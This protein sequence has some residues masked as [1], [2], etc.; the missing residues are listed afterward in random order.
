MIKDL[1]ISINYWQDFLTTLASTYGI[2]F[3]LMD[4][5]GNI[6]SNTVNERTLCSY[7][8]R[9]ENSSLKCKE[10]CRDIPLQAVSEENIK[11]YN[12]Y[13]GI[14]CFAIPI[15]IS[16]SEKGVILGGKVLTDIPYTEAYSEKCRQLGININEV[17]NSLHELK[18]MKEKCIGAYIELIDNFAKKAALMEVDIS[19]YAEK[20]KQFKRI[21]SGI[22][23]LHEN[24]A[25]DREFLFSIIR[26]A[27]EAF[28]VK[29]VSLI[30]KKGNNFESVA[31]IRDYIDTG[32][33]SGITLKSNS[34]LI[35]KIIE[36]GK[37]PLILDDSKLISELGIKWGAETISI[38]PVFKSHKLWGILLFFNF[39]DDSDTRENLRFFAENIEKTIESIE[40][41]NQLKLINHNKMQLNSMMEKFAKLSRI[42]E[43]LNSVVS[44]I[45]AFTKAGRVSVAIVNEET[46]KLEL[47][48]A[49]GLDESILKSSRFIDNNSISYRAFDSGTPIIVDDIS[50]HEDFSQL[51]H[52]GCA[53]NAFMSLPLRHNGRAIGTLNVSEIEKLIVEDDEKYEWLKNRVKL[54]S[55]L[56]EKTILKKE[57]KGLKSKYIDSDKGIY[58]KIYFHEFG[59]KRL[60]NS[61]RNRRSDSVIV[62]NFAKELE[63]ISAEKETIL[64]NIISDA[65]REIRSSDI[66]ALYDEESITFFLPDTDKNGAL[67]FAKKMKSK[68]EDL[69][70]FFEQPGEDIKVSVGVSTFP[71]D[72]DSV[73]NLTLS[74]QRALVN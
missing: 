64:N 50:R 42:E 31:D 20:E 5:S 51:A 70:L 45:S 73:T 46:G 25:I 55:L 40:V 8:S 32:V 52:S 11:R 68:V 48:A 53:G 4:S 62:L 14:E 21:L 67:L 29:D 7:L 37:K 49:K 58:N 24:D 6:V 34:P 59:K 39:P 74:A 17:L 1:K 28:S 61:R 23:E 72:G 41:K 63:K 18:F 69:L 9:F 57:V 60:E 33:M 47:L 43:L 16:K 35:E 2:F 27:S 54:M 30:E 13:M 56:I 38:V 71:E 65:R 36:T 26:T 19:E 3:Q 10:H 44:E 66:M 15:D 12:C 22:N